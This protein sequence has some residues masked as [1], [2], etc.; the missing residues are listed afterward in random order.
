MNQQYKNLYLLTPK[1]PAQLSNLNFTYLDESDGV[2]Y[3]QYR[4]PIEF[5]FKKDGGAVPTLF[6]TFTL[7]SYTWEIT[8]DVK[9]LNNGYYA[10]FYNQE[11]GIHQPLLG[12]I[13]RRINKKL[14]ELQII[15]RK[16]GKK[17]SDRTRM[18]K[19]TGSNMGSPISDKS[20]QR[21][22]TCNKHNKRRKPDSGESI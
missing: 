2:K 15:Q 20:L 1:T 9:T 10:A 22:S 4:F 3:Y 17:T 12:R 6:A 18:Q 13:R 8:V 11:F 19:N 16:V 14:D 5:W 7:N 21:R